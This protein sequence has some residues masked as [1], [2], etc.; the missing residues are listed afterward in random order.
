MCSSDL[1]TAAAPQVAI[2]NET[3]AR[4]F[5]G[6]QDAI[7]R[8]VVLPRTNLGASVRHGTDAYV[9]ESANAE[10]IVRAVKELRRDRA[11]SERLA[12]G[13]RAYW[14]KR[15]RE[16]NVWVEKEGSIYVV[17]SNIQFSFPS[18]KQA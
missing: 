16:V 3:F 18:P 17:R 15:G 2:V 7:G 1:D 9:L 8:P 6:G 13:I 12:A 14:R 5:F 11:L 4:R 10:G